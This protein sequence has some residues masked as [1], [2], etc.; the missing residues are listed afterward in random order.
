MRGGHLK[1]RQHLDTSNIE[2]VEIYLYS[3]F[4][5]NMA[6][7]TSDSLGAWNFLPAKG[8]YDRPINRP[9]RLARRTQRGIGLPKS[10]V[11]D[12]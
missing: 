3:L 2:E 4:F 10:K 7:K 6:L 8:N 5:R 9:T 12:Q 1:I 11:I